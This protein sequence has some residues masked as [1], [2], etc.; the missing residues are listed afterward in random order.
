MLEFFELTI[1]TLFHSGK[2]RE[3]SWNRIA[4]VDAGFFTTNCGQA[5]PLYFN[6]LPLTGIF[7]LWRFH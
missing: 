3:F 4:L 5:V 2:N 1:N 6:Y 7:F